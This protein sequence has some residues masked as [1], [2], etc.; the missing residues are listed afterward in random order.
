MQGGLLIAG[1]REKV[2]YNGD[3][4]FLLSSPHSNRMSDCEG[5]IVQSRAPGAGP[6]F[7]LCYVQTTE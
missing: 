5:L 7:K 2:N 1:E 3:I 6:P 4:H